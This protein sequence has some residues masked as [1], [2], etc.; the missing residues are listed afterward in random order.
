MI[1]Q[2]NT[3]SHNRKAATKLS[4][5]IFTCGLILMHFL[6]DRP[7]TV[8]H[9]TALLTHSCSTSNDSNKLPDVVYFSFSFMSSSKIL[10]FFRFVFASVYHSRSQFFISTSTSC[11]PWNGISTSECHWTIRKLTFSFV[12]VSLSFSVDETRKFISTNEGLSDEEK[13]VVSLLQTLFENEIF[14]FLCQKN[15]RVSLLY[16]LDLV[17]LVQAFLM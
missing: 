17:K 10:S 15:M 11:G 7:R 9:H 14:I 3:M 4:N 8:P 6:Y 1:E 16:T 12:S 5:N 13:N 2:Q